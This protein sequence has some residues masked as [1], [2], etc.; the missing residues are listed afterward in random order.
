MSSS[1]V[2]NRGPSQAQHRLRAR[3]SS[4][5]EGARGFSKFQNVPTKVAAFSHKAQERFDWPHVCWRSL[6]LEKVSQ[7]QRCQV[8]EVGKLF[9]GLKH[10]LQGAT[11]RGLPGRVRLWLIAP[12]RKAAW[13][14]GLLIGWPISWHIVTA[15]SDKA[16][17]ASRKPEIY[18][19]AFHHPFNIR[20]QRDEGES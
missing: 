20:A 9:K 5:W 19:P 18:P 3:R 17:P 7:H 12:S 11:C 16:G 1:T 8:E 4:V 15:A 6:A 13:F 14:S 10:G 2:V